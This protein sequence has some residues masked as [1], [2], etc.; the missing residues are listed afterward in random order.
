VDRSF[1]A[2]KATWLKRFKASG[3]SRYVPPF[4]VLTVSHWFADPQDC[5]KRVQTQFRGRLVAV[6]SSR[7]QECAGVAAQAGR[8]RSVGAVDPSELQML[9]GAIS[10]VVRSYGEPR[11]ADEI[12]IQD[13]IGDAIATIGASSSSATPYPKTAC[14]SHRLGSETHAITAGWTNVQRYWLADGHSPVAHWPSAVRRAFALL[15]HIEITLGIAAFELEIAVD[16][17]GRLRLLQL[18]P[19]T[20]SAPALSFSQRRRGIARLL[21]Q[22]DQAAR[23][24]SGELGS[25]TVLGLMPDW[26]PAELIGEHPRALAASVFQGLI[27]KRAWREARVG[28]G[29]R[30]APTH[31]LIAFIAG[32]PYVDVRA[33]LNSLLPGSLAPSL[34]L[35]VIN[36]SLEKLRL[37]PSLHD[38][39]ET[40]LQPTCTGFADEWRQQLRLAGLNASAQRQ[41]HKSLLMLDTRWNER[42]SGADSLGK[43]VTAAAQIKRS[44]AVTGTDPGALVGCLVDIESAL[45]RVFAA[46]AR[47]AFVARFQLA[48]LARAGAISVS[49]LNEIFGS[50]TVLH[51]PLGIN[52]KA[53][54][55]QRPSTFDIRVPPLRSSNSPSNHA[56]KTMTFSASERR[57]V[58]ALLQTQEIVI[59][60][61]AWLA[62]A[63]GRIEQR[64]QGKYLL[65]EALSN[66]LGAVA[67]WGSTL[68]FTTDDLSHLSLAA[69]QKHRGAPQA[70]RIIARNRALHE[71]QRAIRL[72]ILI[73]RRRDVYASTDSALRPTFSGSGRVTG[74]VQVI[75][76]FTIR[77]TIAAGT[78]VVSRAADPGFDWIFEQPIAALVTCFGG[79][80]SHMAI[81]CG[82]TLLPCVLGCGETTYQALLGAQCISIDLEQRH[83]VIDP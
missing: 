10:A 82:E 49:R 54:G 58:N 66:W 63:Q 9:R 39:I 75:D 48:S 14:V 17:R 38:R 70:A 67:H 83:L 20:Q 21:W 44:I 26:N 64:E 40:E 79:P 61:D 19:S 11:V 35:P 4:A 33:S 47:L 37:Q 57:A 25:A 18:S 52:A 29:Y 62:R 15:S 41:W 59:G 27:A 71:A 76:R 3:L 7:A 46:D 42:P 13:W 45:A 5:I 32:R 28:L 36:T 81:R 22:Y 72:P 69:L 51:S 23:P 6:R 56:R 68:G 55:A 74:R 50:T 77:R 12:L 60:A 53:H 1:Q 80:H 65:A 24:R 43:L 73:T 16:S 78:I 2:S 30:D 34:A 8:Y 31:P